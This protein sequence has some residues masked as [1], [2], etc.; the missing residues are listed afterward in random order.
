MA[1]KSPHRRAADAALS[2]LS[3]A[4]AGA[5]A[6]PSVPA[7][8]S[9]AASTALSIAAT[10]TCGEIGKEDDVFGECGRKFHSAVACLFTKVAQHEN[11]SAAFVSECQKLVAFH[12]V[13]TNM[14]VSE[15]A[16]MF[17]RVL[18]ERYAQLK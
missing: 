14:R 8:E 16:N 9:I 11:G 3:A 15:C 1:Q 5:S 12:E 2:A 10:A 18:D 7:G 6:G 13:P 4:S 17:A